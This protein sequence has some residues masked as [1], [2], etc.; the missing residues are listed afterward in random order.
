MNRKFFS[1][2]LLRSLFT[3]QNS[4]ITQLARRNYSVWQRA[5]AMTAATKANMFN[6]PNRMMMSTHNGGGAHTN[7][8]EERVGININTGETVRQP[9]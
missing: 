8:E 5:A 3:K 4:H 9:A 2:L 6:G 7:N 1:D